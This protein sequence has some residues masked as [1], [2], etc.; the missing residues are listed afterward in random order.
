VIDVETLTG[1]TRWSVDRVLRELSMLELEGRV[2]RIGP[3]R[4]VCLY[5]K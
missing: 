5:R 1:K 4:F 2:S 3:G